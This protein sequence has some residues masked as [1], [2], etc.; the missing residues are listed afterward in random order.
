LFGT[1][2]KQ[3]VAQAHDEMLQRTDEI[4]KIR[5]LQK[6]DS[7]SALAKAQML[8]N[9]SIRIHMFVFIAHGCCPIKLGCKKRYIPRFK[10]RNRRPQRRSRK[11][12]GMVA[13]AKVVSMRPRVRCLLD[14][15]SP[16]LRK[17]QLSLT[18][19][20]QCVRIDGRDSVTWPRL[21]NITQLARRMGL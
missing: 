20:L 11:T 13:L 17:A 14:S 2:T 8:S 6:M 21:R 3:Q 9:S 15:H 4:P 16:F 19:R 5:E 12:G 1:P 10:G 18:K 7:P